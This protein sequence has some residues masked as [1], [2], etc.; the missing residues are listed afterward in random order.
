MG[1]VFVSILVILPKLSLFSWIIAEFRWHS[2]FF[3]L[4]LF[5]IPLFG[6][7]IWWKLIDKEWADKFLTTRHN[8]D[9]NNEKNYDKKSLRNIIKETFL[10]VFGIRKDMTISAVALL[11]SSMSIILVLTCTLPRPYNTPSSVFGNS[12]IFREGI[13]RNTSHYQM[14][15]KLNDTFCKCQNIPSNEENLSPKYFRDNTICK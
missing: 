7:F 3:F 5:L 11:L 6:R 4:P 14:H 10:D 12:S 1:V 8:F 9:T 2:L 13:S 15:P